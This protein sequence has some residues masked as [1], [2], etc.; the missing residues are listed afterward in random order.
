MTTIYYDCSDDV[1]KRHT[2]PDDAIRD[3]LEWH[4]DEDPPERLTAEAFVRV[5]IPNARVES[6]AER[7][8][9]TV[10]EDLDEEYGHEDHQTLD[11]GDIQALEEH[12]RVFMAEVLKRF[13]G[14]PLQH[15]QARDVTVNVREWLA[16]NDP[17]RLQ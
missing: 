13:R 14:H 17:E 6:V 10:H 2:C 7:I 12:A 11:A 4:D 1:V 5:P 8:V 16:E 15:D 9:E 3:W